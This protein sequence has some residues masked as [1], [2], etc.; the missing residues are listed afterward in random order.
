MD[1]RRP[2]AEIIL[3]I[4]GVVLSC[5]WLP[6]GISGLIYILQAVLPKFRVSSS[7][8]QFLYAIGNPLGWYNQQIVRRFYMRGNLRIGHLLNA[9][10]LC[11]FPLVGVAILV[12]AIVLYTRAKRAGREEAV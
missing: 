4:V 6:R 11:L 1:R 12:I 7:I 9:I 3:I 2:V 5:C 8:A 10:P